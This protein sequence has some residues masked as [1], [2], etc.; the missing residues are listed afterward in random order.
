MCLK[1]KIILHFDIYLKSLINF[2]NVTLVS[3]STLQLT[4]FDKLLTHHDHRVAS[5]LDAQYLKEEWEFPEV[6]Y[7]DTKF[8]DST[9]ICG[10]SRVEMVKIIIFFIFK[11]LLSVKLHPFL[12]IRKV[13]V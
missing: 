11:T 2:H 5:D 6:R 8:K 7:K 1:N 9:V 4:D 12:Q 13:F 10:D 3:F